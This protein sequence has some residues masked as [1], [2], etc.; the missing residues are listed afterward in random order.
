MVGA[1]D[2]IGELSSIQNSKPMR[3]NVFPLLYQLPYTTSI[4]IKLL[5][6]SVFRPIAGRACI[7]SPAHQYAPP[8]PVPGAPPSLL[9]EYL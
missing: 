8:R 3:V 2:L 7:K 1:G 9:L 4:A 5:Q 6:L